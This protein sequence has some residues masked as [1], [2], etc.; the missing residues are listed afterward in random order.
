MTGIAWGRLMRLGLVELGLAPG[1]FWDLTPAELMFL[2]GGDS[3]A[4]PMRRSGL[5]AMMTLYPDPTH[6]RGAGDKFAQEG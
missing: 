3:V 6:D 4:A 1:V 5:E 2:A